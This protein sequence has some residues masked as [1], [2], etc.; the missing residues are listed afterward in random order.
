MSNKAQAVA[1]EQRQAGQPVGGARDFL[2]P[3][4]DR[5]R[6]LVG[7]VAHVLFVQRSAGAAESRFHAQAPRAGADAVD[8]EEEVQRRPGEREQPADGD[9]APGG[10]RIATG[11]Q[12]V[13]GGADRDGEP[14]RQQ[15]AAPVFQQQDGA[16]GHVGRRRISVATGR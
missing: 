2:E 16:G 10:A 14:Q 9:P 11:Q 1:V 12:R 13:S 4:R 3:H 15:C 5:V 8:A 6:A 7:A